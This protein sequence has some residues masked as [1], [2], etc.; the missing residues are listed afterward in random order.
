MFNFL[1]LLFFP[2]FCNSQIFCDN[3]INSVTSGSAL[4]FSGGLYYILLLYVLWVTYFCLESTNYV[5]SDVI[6]FPY[7]NFTVSWWMR[8][9]KT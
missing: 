6:N 1:F 7:T 8:V 2:F 9:T 3:V 4:L 5:Y